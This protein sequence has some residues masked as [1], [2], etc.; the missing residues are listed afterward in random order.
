MNVS[1][2]IHSFFFEI[3]RGYSDSFLEYY[4]VEY[5]LFTEILEWF[6]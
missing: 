5:I 2:L 6:L 1:W 3:I 4:L